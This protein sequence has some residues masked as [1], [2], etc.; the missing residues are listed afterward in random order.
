MAPVTWQHPAAAAIHHCAPALS[1]L[2][3]C[4]APITREWGSIASDTV[5]MFGWKSDI[6]KQAPLK[7][8]RV[9]S[10]GEMYVLH[11]C[12]VTYYYSTTSTHYPRPVSALTPILAFHQLGSLIIFVMFSHI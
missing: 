2:A 10:G 3:S 8:P 5:E 6:K 12:S 1:V 4:E 11:H 9:R 7:R